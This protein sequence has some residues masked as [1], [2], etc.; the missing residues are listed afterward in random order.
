MRMIIPMAGKGTRLR[1]HTHTTPKPLLMVG[2]KIM[3][4][5]ILD[6]LT[7]TLEG[8]IEEISF[9]LGDLD[10]DVQQN[11][12]QLLS[13]YK[14]KTS[15]FVQDPPLGTGHAIYMA[16]EKLEGEVLIAYADT[17]FD[18]DL[19]GLSA[20]NADGVI[21]VK[22]VENPSAYGVVVE[23]NGY[24]DKFAEK[25]K[26]P[27]S[28]KAIIGV[29]YF[30]KAEKLRD[31]LQQLIDSKKTVKGEY[32]LTDSLESLVGDGYKFVTRSVNYWLDCGN[33]KSLLDTNAFLLDLKKDKLTVPVLKNSVIIPP[34]F[35]GKNAEIRNSVIGPNVSVA[36]D[37]VID[38]S[39]IQNSIINQHSSLKNIV[40]KDSIIGRF[41]SAKGGSK[42]LNLGDHTE[43]SILHE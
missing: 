15:Y 28:D 25:P 39:I 5:E 4:E 18:A 24:I 2:G 3:L 13:K 27:V 33:M 19:S 38:Q 36:D 23:K 1:P 34:V 40:L 17:I 10:K 21:W 16:K 14:V 8:K 29:Y 42:K 37:V 11:L 32:Q 30:K 22:E 6:T 20:L 35:F 41:V 12:D 7:S 31:H 43:Y 9:I 26:E